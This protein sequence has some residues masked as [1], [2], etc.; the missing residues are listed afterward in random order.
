MFLCAFLNIYSLKG[1]NVQRKIKIHPYLWVHAH[2][3]PNLAIA[4]IPL[5]LEKG[6]LDT[7]YHKKLIR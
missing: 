4:A 5:A 3:V 2:T 1:A 6:I 7:L